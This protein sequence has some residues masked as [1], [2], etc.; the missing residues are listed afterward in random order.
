[1]MMTMLSLPFSPASQASEPPFHLKM[2]P[3]EQ[4]GTEREE[5]GVHSD[6][7]PI[8]LSL[9]YATTATTATT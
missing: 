1:M 9:L 3:N 8:Y 4:G 7:S 6:P 5:G 2:I